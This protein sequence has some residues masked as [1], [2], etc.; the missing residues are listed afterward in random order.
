[1]NAET[2]DH[3]NKPWVVGI[4][5]K[6]PF[7]PVRPSGCLT[8]KY[9][10]LITRYVCTYSIL[11]NIITNNTTN[12]YWETTW[13]RYSSNNSCYNEADYQQ[14][15]PI[16]FSYNVLFFIVQISW[17]FILPKIYQNTSLFISVLQ[18][19]NISCLIIISIP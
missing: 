1:M 16:F 12:S 5:E 6:S 18:I 7:L 17:K 13:I 11:K 4:V 19:S 10:I 9:K 2:S 15:S 14:N 3:L 8:A